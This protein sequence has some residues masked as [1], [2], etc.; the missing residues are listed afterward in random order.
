MRSSYTAVVERNVEV[1]HSFESEPY[2]CGWAT[3]AIFFVNVLEGS[4]A[5]TMLRVQISADGMHWCDEGSTVTLLAQGQAAFVKVKHFGNW[6]RLKGNSGE[7]AGK[8]LVTLHL[9]E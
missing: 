2:E 6:L 9:K 1:R 7:K 3:E 8:I 5:D 4:L